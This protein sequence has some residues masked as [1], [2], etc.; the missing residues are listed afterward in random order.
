[1]VEVSLIVGKL[2]A[3]LALLLTKEHHL[4]EFPTI[5]LPKDVQAGSIVK[6]SCERDEPAEQADKESFLETQDQIMQTFGTF[7]PKSP[8]LRVRNVTETSAVLEWDPIEVATAEVISLTLFKNGARFGIIP[9]PLTRTAIKLSGLAIDTAYTFELV[10]ATTAGT[11]HS[12]E[13]RVKTHKMT[14]LT[15]ITLCVGTIE[16]TDIDRADLEETIR[17]I[18]AKPLQDK[19]QLDTTHFVCTVGEGDQW[20]RALAMNIP[21]VRPEWIK[22]C[23]AE[24]RLVSVRAY[25]LNADPKLRPPV[26]RSR[27]ASQVTQASGELGHRRAVSEITDGPAKPNHPVNNI[28]QSVPEE[29]EETEEIP[30]QHEVAQEKAP[31]PAEEKLTRPV[32]ETPIVEEDAAATEATPEA[33]EEKVSVTE[34]PTKIPELTTEADSAAQ[35]NISSEVQEATPVENETQSDPAAEI[36]PI[37]EEKAEETVKPEEPS[38]VSEESTITEPAAEAE[39]E[40]EAPVEKTE[41]EVEAPVEKAEAE[42][43]APVE[44]TEEDGDMISNGDLGGDLAQDAPEPVT[45]KTLTQQPELVDENGNEEDGDIADLAETPVNT[46]EPAPLS[47]N[48]KKNQKKKAKKAAAAAAAAEADKKD[49]G[50]LEEVAL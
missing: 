24:R 21:V 30:K 40:V 22:A 3:S 47:K 28:P 37:A 11:Y 46:D 39:A 38:P 29:S 35:D 14:D 17:N 50:D 48:A 10:L 8:N 31:E 20:K 27:A 2:D 23:E 18:G 1:M 42:V 49:D 13:L 15:G 36:A 34:V 4:I 9:S 44:K 12:E 33:A 5:L 16:D 45:A 25:Y 26:Q 32:S 7:S 19:V 6:I 43:E 41:A